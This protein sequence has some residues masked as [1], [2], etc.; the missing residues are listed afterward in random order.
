MEE[1]IQKVSG[2]VLG[3]G[4]GWMDG[5]TTNIGNGGRRRAGGKKGYGTE[6]SDC[7]HVSF[8]VPVVFL[9]PSLRS[10]DGEHWDLWDR[11]SKGAQR[12]RASRGQPGDRSVMQ[13]K[14]EIGI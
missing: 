2:W 6:N 12:Q 4:P 14:G 8:E 5:G 3:F 10:M 7:R 9:E 11:Q 1:G 13:P